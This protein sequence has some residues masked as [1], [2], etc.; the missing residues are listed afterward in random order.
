[1]KHIN[2]SFFRAETF[3]FVFFIA[4]VLLFAQ[5]QASFAQNDDK[6]LAGAKAAILIARAKDSIEKNKLDAAVSDLAAAIKLEENNDAAYTQR[7]RAYVLLKNFEAAD[8]DAEKAL[9]INPKNAEAL[10]IRGVYKQSREQYDA[11]IADYTQVIAIKPGFV[12]AYLN[13]GTSFGAKD[14][15]EKSAADFRKVL[16]LEPGNQPAK[17]LLEKIAALRLATANN[18][19][20]AE[21]DAQ[22]TAR[23]KE[24]VSQYNALNAS[25]AEKASA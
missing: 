7:A 17:Q 2:K 21:T 14:E 24:A 25:Y 16:E 19:A 11:A 20:A 6:S 12:K 3:G 4:L 13:R 10:N 1:M 18:S 8:V 23:L 9:S 22:A 15:L 5:S